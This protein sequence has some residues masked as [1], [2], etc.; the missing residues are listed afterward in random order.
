[1]TANPV[2]YMDACCF[3]DLAKSALSVP[4][5]RER[6]PHIFYCRKFLDAARAKDAVVYTSTISVVECVNIKDTTAPGCPIVE[7]DGAR[8]LFRGMLMS[9][10]SGVMPV[11]PMP[12]I[13]ELARDL[14][15]VHDI[16]C[17]P[18][19]AVHIATALAMK[20]SHMFSTDGRL[21]AENIRKISALGLT[22]CTADRAVE[23]L[24]DQYRQYTLRPANDKTGH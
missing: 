17:K 18:V 13:T 24:P 21:G 6:E 14:R 7:D 3:I 23:L 1:M 19:D 15:W 11:M 22:V 2:V 10:K 8:T 20:C 12:K 4:T 9:A 5:L 16:T